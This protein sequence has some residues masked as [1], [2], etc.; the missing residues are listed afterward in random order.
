[1]K[2]KMCLYPLEQIKQDRFVD[3]KTPGYQSK[4]LENIDKEDESKIS[5]NVFII[6]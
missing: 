5:N 3:K 4:I 6:I 1:M 2:K